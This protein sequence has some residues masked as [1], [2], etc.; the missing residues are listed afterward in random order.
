MLFAWCMLGGL[1][2][3]FSPRAVTSKFQFA[4]A[5]FFHWP[6]SAGRNVPLAAKTEVPA[7]NDSGRKETQYQNYIANLEEELRQKNQ[8]VQQ[9][10]NSRARLRGLE[11]AK[12]VPADIITSS[13]EGLRGELIINRGSD[14]GLAKG[15]FVI[16]DNSV[17]GTITEL[18]ERSAKVRLLS[19]SSSTVQVNIPSVEINMLM[20][21]GGGNLAKIKLVP[22]K[23]KINAGDEVL[24][25]KKPGFLDIAMIA[26]TVQQCKRDNKNPAL[27]DIT[28]KPACDI[29][30]LNNVAVIVM[31]PNLTPAK[32]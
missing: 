12:L 1:I 14:D 6:L 32:Q 17:I 2:L 28:V 16:G 25:R 31:N 19:D 3:L 22:I 20:Q 24:V 9:L 21:G 30:K 27:W 23:H 26:G 7:Q 13:I 18:S 4:F 5:R 10:T 15:L 29:G 8:M 11:G